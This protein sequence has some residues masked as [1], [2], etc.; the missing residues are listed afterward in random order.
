MAGEQGLVQK[1]GKFLREVKVELKKVIW[2]SHKQT[3]A[4]TLVV[5]GAVLAMSVFMWVVDLGFSSLL[6]LI[7]K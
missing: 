3:F 2:P 4:F 7:I 1:T 6:S 5:L